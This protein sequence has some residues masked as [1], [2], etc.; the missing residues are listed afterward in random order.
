MRTTYSV[1]WGV[2][3]IAAL[4]VTVCW[5]LSHSANTCLLLLAC[6]L[7]LHLSLGLRTVPQKIT[8][9][10]FDLVDSSGKSRVIIGIESGRAA[11]GVLDDDGRVRISLGAPKSG[12]PSIGLFD[13]KGEHGVVIAVSPSGYSG[14]SLSDPEG[15][16]L[17][18]GS[19]TGQS[20]VACIV[21]SRNDHA[22]WKA[23]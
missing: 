21:M 19:E 17:D 4:A 23:P 9:R 13:A 16:S 20:S 11:I 10:Q 7:L 22:V 18:L 15:F 8:A 2:Y 14:I 12:E 5:F 3:I 1:W 6:L